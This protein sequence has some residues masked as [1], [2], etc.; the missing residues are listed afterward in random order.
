M[1]DVY[2]GQWMMHIVLFTIT[3]VHT[4][5]CTHTLAAHTP[6]LQT[7]P[8]AH[9]PCC[10]H[11]LAAHAKTSVHALRPLNPKQT[12]FPPQ[13]QHF[14]PACTQLSIAQLPSPPLQGHLH[15]QLLAALAAATPSVT[16]ALPPRELANLVV[17]LDVLSGGDDCQGDVAMV[18]RAVMDKINASSS[19]VRRFGNMH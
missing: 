6:L 8:A 4:P 5:C 1:C 17:A 13:H 7:H 9:T 14:H 11:T 18:L 12:V 3:D 10:T 15:T 2:M 19:E 16:Q